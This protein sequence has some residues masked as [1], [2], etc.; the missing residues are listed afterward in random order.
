M[1][2]TRVVVV[3]DDLR[4][5]EALRLLF[6]HAQGFEI[7]DLFDSASGAL[8][9]A[10]AG[11]DSPAWDLVFMDIEMPGLDGITGTRQLKAILPAVKV[12]MLTAFED[13]RL[14][15]EAICAGADGYLLKKASHREL[16]QHAAAIM[17]G[18]APLTAGV[19]RTVLD[20]VRE[21]RGARTAGTSI[22]LSPRERDVLGR[23]V[24]GR[25]YKQVAADLDV[26][27]DTVRT[28]IRSLYKKLQVHSVSAAVTRALREG[29]V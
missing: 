15:L 23:L 29:L 1:S 24:E 20:L 9:A 17:H 8:D 5:A 2:A 27:I 11:Q 3:E 18:G 19:A 10:R 21:G 26:S 12:V 6:D 13:S 7:A 22:H 25:S 16:L 28:Y 4:Y 14:I